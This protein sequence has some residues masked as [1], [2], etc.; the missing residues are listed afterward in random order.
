[1]I[2]SWQKSKDGLSMIALMFYIPLEMVCRY[3]DIKS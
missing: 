2:L 1:M 3:A